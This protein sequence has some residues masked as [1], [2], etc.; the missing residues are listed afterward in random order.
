MGA[1]RR[2]MILSP[3]NVPMP[4]IRQYSLEQ[5]VQRRGKRIDHGDAA[6]REAV[7]EILTRQDAAVVFG[8]H[9]QH[10]GIPDWQLVIGVQVHRGLQGRP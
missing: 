9:G 5:G 8:G 2:V 10:Q 1:Q 3:P 6:P 4:S 7:L